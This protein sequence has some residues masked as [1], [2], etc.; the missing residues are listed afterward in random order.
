MV[1]A[2]DFYIKLSIEISEEVSRMGFITIGLAVTVWGT[3]KIIE[4]IAN[5]K[6]N[7]EENVK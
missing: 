5:A 2:S 4:F 7:N 3:V 1:P 6:T